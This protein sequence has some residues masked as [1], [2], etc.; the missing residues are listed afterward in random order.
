[1]GNKIMVSSG[2]SVVENA[3][4]MAINSPLRTDANGLPSTGAIALGSTDVS[5]TLTVGKGGTGISTYT[6]GDLLY[7]SDASTLSTL[8]PG[9]NGQVLTVSGGLPSW[10]TPVAG[11]L[12]AAPGTAA[13]P[14]YAFT[15]D[16]NTGIYS[17]I[18]DEIGVSTA[19]IERLRVAASGNVGIG[20]FAPGA[21]LDVKGAIRMSGSSSGYTGFKPAAAAGG[22]VWELPAIDGSVGQVLTT[23]GNGILS[24]ASAGGGGETNTAS[25]YGV[26]GVGIFDSKNGVDL[27]LKNIN[28]SS[29]KLSVTNDPINHEV[30][31]DVNEANLTL[32]NLGGTLSVAKGGTGSSDGSITGSGPLSFN[33]G[34][35]NQNVSIT[36][37]GAGITII[38]SAVKITGG[39]PG[40]GKILVATDAMGNAA[41]QA[42][43]NPLI[44]TTTASYTTLGQNNNG[45]TAGHT[46]IGANAGFNYTGAATLLGHNAGGAGGSGSS[47]TLIGADSN[48]STQMNG[49]QNTSVGAG[50]TISAGFS[51]ALVL[52]AGSSVTGDGGVA[53]GVGA[54]APANSIV[55]GSN[56]GVSFK[57]RIRVN[58]SG[59]VGLGTSSPTDSLSIHSA[60]ASNS[61]IGISVD[62]SG[63]TQQAVLNFF[64]Q[65]NGSGPFGFGTP[66]KG[67]QFYAN[68]AGYAGSPNDFGLTFFDGTTWKQSL[69]MQSSTGYV[70]VGKTAPGA[71]LDVKGE[72]RLSGSTSGYTG[73]RPAP[74][75]GSTV[76]TLPTVDGS[77]G[78]VLTT[79][80]AQILSWT[81]P[82]GGGTVTNV[83]S[84]NADISVA[85]GTLTPILTL[86]SG[87]LGG[88]GDANKIAKLD[89]A[90]MLVSGMI[91]NL[92]VSQ[93]T[94]GTLPIARG[95]TNS[96]TALFNNRIM[97][98]IGGAIVEAPAINASRALISDL[99]GIPIDSTVTSTE[100]S[101]LSGISSSVQTQ[102][103]GKAANSG[104]TNNSVM[105]VNGAGIL[106]P[107]AGTTGNTILQWTGSG[108]VWSFASYPTSTTANQLLYSSANNIVSGISTTN[109]AVLTTDGLGVPSWTPL[110][111]DAFTQYAFLLGRSGGQTFNGGVFP[112]E[113]LILDSTTA[114]TKG[115]VIINPTGGNVGIGTSTPSAT[116][117][118][119]GSAKINGAL[120]V[121]GTIKSIPISIGAVATIDW[122][123]SNTFYIPEALNADCLATTNF[124][125][126]Q[127]GVSYTF[128]VKDGGSSTYN[129]CDFIFSSDAGITILAARFTPANT[130]RSTGHTIYNFFRV[131]NHVYISWTTGLN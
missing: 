121:Q 131:G 69:H 114:T 83:S 87:T 52:G 108:P 113:D 59:K 111:N 15:G 124:Q 19:G 4:V 72:V 75:A 85:N 21:P 102:I 120:Q 95:G 33:A 58:S 126:I 8:A 56:T 125:N 67:W 2:T 122:S 39:S 63:A 37:T 78:Q 100:L 88:A 27:R 96:S 68:G 45:A 73:F 90:G 76:W 86:N 48:S 64:T 82:G 1:M 130:A 43:P 11:A 55:I 57:E 84:A 49:S 3:N 99:N 38:N 94:T 36:P 26:G 24:W 81:S 23:S 22:T 62:G 103:N 77:A 34:G 46:A 119:V 12:P 29:S 47:N 5:G 6:A 115:N 10:T 80:G 127:E 30:V 7:A 104:W 61:G 9:S 110:T 74:A 123:Q 32:G 97:A 54:T 20:T 116:L 101:Y 50:T 60:A 89:G 51:K 65:G 79:N 28:V 14:G 105:G 31:L 92:D 18:A 98:S 41:W 93:V 118:V 44:G 109:N 128:I 112:S 16:L 35:T 66:G 129:K 117:D 13:V 17:P 25:N 42:T 71:P 106:N 91:P 40:A 70:G 107:I 53:I